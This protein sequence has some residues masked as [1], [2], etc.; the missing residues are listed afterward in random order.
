MNNDIDIFIYTV[1]CQATILFYTHKWT[2]WTYWPFSI[3][4]FLLIYQ[5]VESI[6]SSKGSKP[7]RWSTLVFDWENAFLRQGPFLEIQI[8]IRN[9]SSAKLAF[10]LIFYFE[11]I[12]RVVE[13]VV[14]KRVHNWYLHLLFLFKW[15]STEGYSN[16]KPFHNLKKT[17]N[18]F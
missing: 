1:L 6:T 7:G 11:E 17:E 13:E 18:K 10:I 4:E 5:F 9:G 16:L 2:K 12:K 14:H 15:Q 3:L 8:S